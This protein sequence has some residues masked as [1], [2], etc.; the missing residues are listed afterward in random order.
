MKPRR[1]YGG[2]KHWGSLLEAKLGR[3]AVHL[4][5]GDRYGDT[6]ALPSFYR[7]GFV[8]IKGGRRRQDASPRYD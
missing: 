1:Y 4:T 3:G 6:A 7:D 8:P 5:K 2:G